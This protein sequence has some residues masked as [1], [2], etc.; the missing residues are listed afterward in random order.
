MFQDL[1]LNLK[2]KQGLGSRQSEQHIRAPGNIMRTGPLPANL[3]LLPIEASSRHPSIAQ[4]AERWTVEDILAG[5]HRS[6]VRLRL[7][8]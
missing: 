4:L 8:G 7:D 2:N 1:T 6:L 5:I 3:R